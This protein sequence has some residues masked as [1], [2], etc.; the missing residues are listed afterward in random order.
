MTKKLLKVLIAI[1]SMIVLGLLLLIAAGNSSIKVSRFEV[2]VDGLP[3]YFTDELRIVHIS[4]IHGREFGTNNEHLARVIEQQ[5]PDLIFVSGDMIDSNQDDGSAFINL[6]YELK[7]HYPVYCS[8]GNH[9]LI[10]KGTAGSDRYRDFTK[11]LREAGAILLDNERAEVSWAGIPV[12][13]YGFTA[14]LYHY[15]G[16]K[17]AYWEGA[18]LTAQ[19]IEE[20]IGSP[21]ASEISVLLSHNPKYFEQYVQWGADL[22][23]SGHIHGGVVRL[24]FIGGVLSPDLTFFPPYSAGT[25]RHGTAQMHVSRGLGDSVI[26]FRIFNRPDVS[27]IILKSS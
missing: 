5:T 10:V 14:M 16:S 17:T 2:S 3:E 13:I 21:K 18:L 23:F 4:D 6:L 12:A 20:T 27:L 7:G 19:H 15:T 8:L 1:I 25:Y 9:E 26:S 22:V 24:P 11:R